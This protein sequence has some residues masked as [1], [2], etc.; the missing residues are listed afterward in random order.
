MSEN[1]EVFLPEE[2]NDEENSSEEN[3]SEENSSEESNEKSNKESNNKESNNKESSDKESSDTNND[4][5]NEYLIDEALAKKAQDLVI[6]AGKIQE[7]IKKGDLS[8]ITSEDVFNYLR[9]MNYNFT[10]LTKIIQ[11]MY[12]Q[13]EEMTDLLVAQHDD[14]QKIT[15][16]LKGV[17]EA[18]KYVDEIQN[19]N[20]ENSSS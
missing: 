2:N 11:M 7:K 20:E 17:F 14:V 19:Q 10:S 1:D 18:G 5:E 16:D 13:M 12:T 8:D 9:V 3:S 6:L 15:D 4:I